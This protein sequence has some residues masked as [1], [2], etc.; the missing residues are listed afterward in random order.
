[1]VRERGKN[2]VNAPVGAL[3]HDRRRV[4][5]GDWDQ[6][7]LCLLQPQRGPMTPTLR[8]LIEYFILLWDYPIR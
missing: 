8:Y 6:H 2:K 5:S 4:M 3:V 7:T 1:M